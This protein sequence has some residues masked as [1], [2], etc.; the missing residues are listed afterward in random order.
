MNDEPILLRKGVRHNARPSTLVGYFMMASLRKIPIIFV[1]ALIAY[2]SLFRGS[3]D[4]IADDPGLGWHLANGKYITDTGTVP[5]VD[6]F[7]ATALLPNP[8]APT[9]QP[10]PW[11]NEQWFGDIVLFELL[12][13]GGWPLVYGVVAGLYF[14]AYFGI[15]G[16]LAR[17]AGEG[18]LVALLGIVL[19]F[20]L[21]QVHLI[22]RPVLFSIVLFSFFLRRCCAMASRKEFSWRDLSREGVI[23]CAVMA[24]WAN[25]H[26]A[27]IYG[28]ATLALAIVA[29][30]TTGGPGRVNALKLAGILVLCVGASCLNPFGAGL[31][32]SILE[33]GANSRLRAVTTEW[34]P[35]DLGQVEGRLLLALSLIPC[36]C[37]LVSSRMR[38]GIGIFDVLLVLFFVPQALWAVRVVPFA[39]LACLPLWVSCFGGKSLLPELSWT[40]LTR[41]ALRKIDERES[42]VLRPGLRSSLVIA[43]GGAAVIFFFPS[44]VLPSPIGSNQER[45][46]V[47]LFPSG[48]VVSGVVFASPDW[49]GAITHLLW[50]AARPVLDDR[51]VVVGEALYRAYGES[52]RSPAKFNE[53][54]RVFGVTDVL[55]PENAPLASYLSGSEEWQRLRQAHNVVR[56]RAR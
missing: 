44:H 28:L 46:L 23:L 1:F 37:A 6:P 38:R 11:I 19:A 45:R 22:V 4:R 8:Y 51:T 5:S 17:H 14:V 29:Q 43:I 55:V 52:M 40:L 53:L 32:E 7:L 34:Y 30:C 16:D 3:F 15:A 31:Y 25:L 20:K 9:N 13:S 33:L 48:N 49:G 41:N 21:G 10:R 42:K 39:S 26:P 36:T 18:L 50:P 24:V 47:E 27:F 35:I 56:F 12:S 2:L 54:V